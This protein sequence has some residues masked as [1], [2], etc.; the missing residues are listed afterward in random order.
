MW[1]WRWTLHHLTGYQTWGCIFLISITGHLVWTPWYRSLIIHRY[2]TSSRA[3]PS[4]YNSRIS[5]PIPYHLS[6]PPLFSFKFLF[7]ETMP[8]NRF[9]IKW[10]NSY[11]LLL[12]L[13][14]NSI[15]P[16]VPYGFSC[17][18]AFVIYK[19]LSKWFFLKFYWAFYYSLYFKNFQHLTGS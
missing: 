2:V 13:Q 11:Y 10:Y 4:H 6:I 17:I 16:T 3:W 1:S 15:S 18:Q 5:F 8:Q 9:C 12:L 14:T 19:I 7:F